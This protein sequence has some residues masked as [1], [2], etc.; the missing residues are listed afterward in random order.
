MKKPIKKKAEKEIAPAVSL[1]LR[2]WFAGQA[3]QGLV[4][5]A[6]ARSPIVSGGG[7]YLNESVIRTSWELADMMMKTRG[8]Q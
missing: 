2:E 4:A 6:L 3:L 7:L 1:S 5:G 8:P